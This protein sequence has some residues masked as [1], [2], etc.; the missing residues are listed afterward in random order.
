MQP[1]VEARLSGPLANEPV[2][3]NEAEKVQYNK[4]YYIFAFI[5][6][7]KTFRYVVNSICFQNFLYR[8]LKLL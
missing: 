6:K 3:N 7:K 5:E 2:A 8:Y 4:E 1:V